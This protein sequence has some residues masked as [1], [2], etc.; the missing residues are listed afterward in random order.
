MGA[1][2][3]Y[4]IAILECI[5]WVFSLLGALFGLWV[6]TQEKK[7]DKAITELDAN[8][9]PEEAMRVD[10]DPQQSQEMSPEEKV[11]ETNA[12]IDAYA[13]AAP[14]LIVAALIGIH[15]CC[16]GLKASKGDIV[17]A[18]SYYYWKRYTVMFAVLSMIFGLN[19]GPMGGLVGLLVSV[20]YAAVVRS[21]YIS[22]V[23]E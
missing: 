11:S 13:M 7:I 23:N 22:L 10:Q 17:A 2:G 4:L 14:F 6:K 15:F 12:L 16:K 19:G 1:T 18:T 5:S 3:V 21:Y 20:Y 9:P 8:A